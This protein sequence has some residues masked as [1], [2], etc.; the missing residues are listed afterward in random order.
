M[1]TTARAATKRARAIVASRG[2][3][4]CALLALGASLGC[5]RHLSEV[6][7]VA[8]AGGI[9]AET[10]CGPTTDACPDNYRCAGSCDDPTTGK[11]EPIPTASTCTGDYSPVCDCN[12]ITYF[13]DCLRQAAQAN[14]EVTG[15]CGDLISCDSGPLPCLNAPAQHCSPTAP[16]GDADGGESCALLVSSPFPVPAADRGAACLLFG[17]APT[18]CWVLPT[19]CT[20]GD[21]AVVNCGNEGVLSTPCAALKLGGT[22]FLGSELN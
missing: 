21:R 16:C 13:N 1:T 15:Q 2:V 6:A 17:I 9:D 18:V 4:G 5:G 11:C 14:L 19:S 7:S 20:T 8:D 10:P 12:G 3:L 22:S